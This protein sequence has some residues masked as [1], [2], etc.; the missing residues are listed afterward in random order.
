MVSWNAARGP[1]TEIGTEQEKF[2][3]G[4][5]YKVECDKFREHILAN[6]KNA[7]QRNSLSRA[8]SR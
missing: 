6:L 2:I 4:S 8:N 7:K 5:E 3:L 1:G